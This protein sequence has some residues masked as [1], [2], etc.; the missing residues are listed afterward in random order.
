MYSFERSGVGTEIT[1]AEKAVLGDNSNP[2]SRMISCSAQIAVGEEIVAVCHTPPNM[3]CG[4][5]FVD[6]VEG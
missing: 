1:R 6:S 4:Y 5:T 2:L 3:T